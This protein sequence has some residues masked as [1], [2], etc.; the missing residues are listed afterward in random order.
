MTRKDLRTSE[1]DWRA[2]KQPTNRPMP[3]PKKSLNVL[4]T[5][6]W[7]AIVLGAL[8]FGS[9]LWESQKTCESINGSNSRACVD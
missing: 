9:L 8:L 4:K 5:L 3:T 7:T 2:T 1:S 6:K